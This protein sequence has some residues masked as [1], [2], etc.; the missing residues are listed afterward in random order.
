[1]AREVER[2][3]QNA[4]VRGTRQRRC[5]RR[6]FRCSERLRRASRRLAFI[7]GASY[8]P[9]MPHSALGPTLADHLPAATGR[10]WLIIAGVWSV[11]ALLAACET[12]MF[13]RLG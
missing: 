2:C 4:H 1:M 5:S 8:R 9:P 7:L 10:R 11:P 13:W 6:R 3:A 12:W